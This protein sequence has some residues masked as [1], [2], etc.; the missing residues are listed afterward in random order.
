MVPGS[1]KFRGVIKRA[2]RRTRHRFANIFSVGITGRLAMSFAAVGIL[3]AAANLIVERGVAVVHT[4]RL[5]RAQFSPIPSFSKPSATAPAAAPAS[6]PTP[7]PA[8]ADDPVI[9]RRAEPAPARIHID[10]FMGAVDRF[11]HAITERASVNSASTTDEVKAATQDLD[12][13]TTDVQVRSGPVAAAAAPA[14]EQGLLTYVE[15]GDKYLQIADARRAARREYIGRSEAMDAR[16]S[17]SLGRDWKIFGH[18]FARQSLVQLHTDLEE[19]R[20]RFAVI[21][22]SDIYDAGA[23][24]ALANSEHALAATFNRNEQSFRRTEGADW[25]RQIRDDM[26]QLVMLRESI[27]STDAK[28]RDGALEFADAQKQ[29]VD[30]IPR[31]PPEPVFRPAPSPPAA[32]TPAVPLSAD[33]PLSTAVPQSTAVLI[34]AVASPIVDAVTTNVPDLERQRTTIACIT[35]A[36]LLVLLTISVLTVRSIIIPVSRMLAATEKLASGDVDVRVPRGGIKELDTLAISFNRMAAQLAAARDMTQ[37]YR[38]HLETQ[39]TQRTRQ[40]QYL[41][42]HDPL[43]LLPN[44]RKFFS[45]FNDSLQWAAKNQR[46]VAVFFIDVDNFKNLNDSMGHAFGDRVLMS[47]A[48]RLEETSKSFGYAARLGGDEFTV[49]HQDAPS[50]QGAQAAGRKLVE[51]FQQPL[52]VDGREVTVS[53]SVGASLY[54][55]HELRA[56]DLL[57]AADA[58]L[59]RAKALGRSQLAIFTPEL[60]ETATRK[61]TTEQG[62]RR[63]IERSEF[64]LVFQPEVSLNSLEMELAEALI[65]WRMPDGRLAQPDE[66]LAVTEESGLII[67]VGNWVLRKAIETVAGW[68]HGEWPEAKIAINVSSRQ[69]LDHRFVERVQDLLHEFK[70]PPHCIEFELTESVLQTGPTTLESLR[71]LRSLDIAIALDDF[72]TGYSSLASLER[73][74]LSRIKLDRTLI[75]GID[76]NARSAA[77]TVALI[78]LCDSLGLEVTAEGVERAAQ[79][80]CLAAYRT[81]NLQ[82]YLISRPVAADQILRVRSLIPQIMGDLLL[83][84]PAAQPMDERSA[85]RRRSLIRS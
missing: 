22:A 56:E 66:F 19:L 45:L 15:A 14:I 60:L 16:I 27:V 51:A 52:N 18:V 11:Q 34:P 28:F 61:F 6:A 50:T 74:P 63:A 21:G 36:V 38:R 4:T 41:A 29:L 30:A 3:A 75:A 77:I 48:Q 5:D 76:T 7:A 44:R 68:H 64:E 67:E 83:S 72:G 49:V 62:L 43:T 24:A 69:L 84:I 10:S 46:N 26:A 47:V 57:S 33:A 23:V 80:G 78:K 32:Q 82:G 40:L 79:F 31:P 20:R 35:A 13:A 54:P 1:G 12:T 71:H 37:D 2:W 8:P 58:A 17:A 73:L 55:D 9:R 25:I 81:M 59:F 39:V 53:V 42:E 85:G 70:V 65:R